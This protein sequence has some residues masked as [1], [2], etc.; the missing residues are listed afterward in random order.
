MSSGGGFL[1][2]DALYRPDQGSPYYSWYG[3]GWKAYV[4]YGCGVLVN[5]SGFMDSLG[6]QGVPV[7]MVYVYRLN[8]FAG[9][10]LAGAVYFLLCRREKACRP[11][12]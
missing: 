11:Q 4:R 10:G 9:F 5:L 6:V 7:V 8:F 1:D 12:S 3:W 2:L